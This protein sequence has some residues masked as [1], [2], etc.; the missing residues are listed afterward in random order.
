MSRI[1]HS[2]KFDLGRT[3]NGEIVELIAPLDSRGQS[4]HCKAV[5][6]KHQIIDLRVGDDIWHD[7]S[8]RSYRVKGVE[9]YRDNYLDDAS[10]ETIQ[11]EGYIVRGA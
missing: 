8:R 2:L 6:P 1:I 10:D 11:S 7:G 4:P 5:M 9:A 3:R